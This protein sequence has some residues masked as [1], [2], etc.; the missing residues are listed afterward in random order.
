[1]EFCVYAWLRSG[2]GVAAERT[3]G[4]LTVKAT[5][6]HCAIYCRYITI[7]KPQNNSIPADCGMLRIPQKPNMRDACSS[8]KS[9]SRT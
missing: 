2:C 7:S 5:T 3:D 9:R 4:S 1:M 6:R 8:G